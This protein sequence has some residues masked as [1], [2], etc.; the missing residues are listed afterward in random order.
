MERHSSLRPEHREEILGARQLR[1]S[2]E[3]DRVI[4]VTLGLPRPAD[5]DWFCPY[6]I[7]GLDKPVSDGSYGGDAIHAIQCALIGI[8]TTLDER[9]LTFTWVFPDGSGT[10]EEGTSGF[11]PSVPGWYGPEI[12]AHL[13]RLIVRETRRLLGDHRVRRGPG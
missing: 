9:G 6:W 3:E 1:I 5:A 4:A 10:A 7:T 8:R 2:D 11:L 13:N 12:E